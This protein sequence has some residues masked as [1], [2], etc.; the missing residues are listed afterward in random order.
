MFKQ[1]IH[2]HHK[3]SE[4]FYHYKLS[5][6]CTVVVINEDHVSVIAAG[7]AGRFKC[8]EIERFD[9]KN[10]SK[11]DAFE[12]IATYIKVVRKIED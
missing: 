1:N 3:K 6:P 2:D 8:K 12:I 9:G 4:R 7:V 5:R 11:T 10:Q